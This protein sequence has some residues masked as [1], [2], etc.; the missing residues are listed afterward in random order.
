ML[1][2]PCKLFGIKLNQLEQKLAVKANVYQFLP[3]IFSC[4]M[5]H[6]LAIREIVPLPSQSES[7]D[8]VMEIAFQ[9]FSRY[10]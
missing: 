7:I 5:L 9:T 8:T 10:L 3:M 2:V 6:I 4:R 1:S